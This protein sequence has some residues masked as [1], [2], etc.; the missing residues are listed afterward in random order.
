M[1]APAQRRPGSKT[2]TGPS[3]RRRRTLNPE[4]RRELL[5]QPS[6]RY[7]TGVRNRALMAVMLYAGLR[8]AEALELRPRDV[9]LA[10]YYL[11]VRGKGKKERTVPI[12]TTLE[13]ILEAWRARRPSGPRFFTTLVGKPVG[14]RYVRRMVGR[15]GEKAGLE[16][17]HPHLLRH[18][19]ASCWLNEKGLSLREVQM[20]LGHS[21]IATTEIYVHANPDEIARKL[22]AA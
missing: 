14:D 4:Q 1:G 13:P 7:P 19:C 16:A 20:L 6:R 22:R 2:R 8:C 3:L 11:R 5:A 17:L 18:A 12:D 9:D 21:R 10:S 15:Y